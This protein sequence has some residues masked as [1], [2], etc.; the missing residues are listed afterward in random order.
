MT[1]S[2]EVTRRVEYSGNGSTTVFAYSFPIFADADAVVHIVSSA[3]IATLQTIT[4]HYT[5]SGAGGDSG[6]NITMVAAPASDETLVIE[7]SLALKQTVDLVNNDTFDAETLETALDRLTLQ[8]QETADDIARSMVL[9]TSATGSVSVTLPNPSAS[10]VLAWNSDE[11]GIEN[12]SILGT[13]RGNWATSTA[14]NTRDIVKDSS[15]DNIYIALNDYTSGASV[16]ADVSGSDLELVLNASAAS[17]SATAAAVSAAAALVSENAAAADLVLTNADVVLTNADV[18][19]TN[20]DVVSTNADV[21]STAADLVATNQDT[22]DTAADLALTNADVVL[23][24]LDVIASAAS[25]AAASTSE[26][27]AAASATTA[28][29]AGATAGAAAGAAAAS[30]QAVAMAIALG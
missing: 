29:T 16:A 15:N 5:V 28:A 25:A 18:V 19:L 27:N 4:T 6:G 1:V 20:A 23:T 21:V 10:R 24:G 8:T 14:Y 2:T 11:D 7:S 3:G 26:T 13:W 9:P 30:E 17:T 22:I 12:G